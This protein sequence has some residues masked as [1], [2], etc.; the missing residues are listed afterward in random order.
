MTKQNVLITGATGAIGKSIASM[1][2]LK[3]NYHVFIVARNPEK[4]E[5]CLAQIKKLS[6]NEQVSLLIA[7]L[8]RKEDIQSLANKWK[9]PLHILINNAAIAPPRR[10]ETKEGLEMQF[11]TNVLSYFWMTEL[12]RNKMEIDS[13]RVVNVASYWAGG[14]DLKDLE[15]KKRSY[16]NDHAYRQS[17]QANRM[18]SAALAEKFPHIAINSCHPGDVSSQLSSDLGFGGYETPE[19]G[20]KTPLWLATDSAGLDNS[21]KYFERMREI[22]CPF[23]QDSEAV[24]ELYEICSTY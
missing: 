7:D 12:F 5:T 23:C 6:E 15:F 16:D 21:G 24:K 1:I 20:A 17:K 10:K 3:P 2:A 22:R 8:S 18:L 19:Q 11:A 13:G 9:E 14:L 4:G